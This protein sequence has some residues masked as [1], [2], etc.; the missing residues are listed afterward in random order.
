[1][2]HNEIPEKPILM[3]G[4]MVKA[5]LA[6][7]KTQTRRIVKPQPINAIFHKGKWIQA[8]CE[9]D[10]KGHELK[11]PYGRPGHR[12]W[13]KEVHYR[14]GCWVK[15]GISETGKQKWKFHPLTAAVRYQDSPPSDIKKNTFRKGG[16]YKRN[17][18]FMPRKCARTFLEITDIRIERLQDISEA[19]AI[20][21]GIKR[22]GKTKQFGDPLYRNYLLHAKTGDDWNCDRS[23]KYSFMT[24]WDSINGKPNP[25]KPDYSWKQNCWVWVVEFK[26]VKA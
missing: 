23:A 25:G 7:L 10:N 13:V 17:S 21:E 26:R 22:V 14:Y 1:M 9:A 12:L 15:N 19:D 11:S 20:K 6:D 3:N 4:A 8:P 2:N 18:L 16:W 5:T 24:L